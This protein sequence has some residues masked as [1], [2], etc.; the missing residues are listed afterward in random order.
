MPAEEIFFNE[1]WWQE[2]FVPKTKNDHVGQNHRADKGPQERRPGIHILQRRGQAKVQTV[3]DSDGAKGRSDDKGGEEKRF[4][5]QVM[6]AATGVPTP[7]FGGYL[8]G[9]GESWF[10]QFSLQFSHGQTVDGHGWSCCFGKAG[11]GET[12]G[13]CAQGKRVSGR[14]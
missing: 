10:A 14:R 11:S 5:E 13:C 4:G 9:Q 3:D 7:S 1:P 12:D 2:R 6:W 8:P